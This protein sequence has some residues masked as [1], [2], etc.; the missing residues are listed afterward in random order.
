MGYNSL[1]K[2]KHIFYIISVLVY[3]ICF[4]IFETYLSGGFSCLMKEYGKNLDLMP[5]LQ[6]YNDPQA[7]LLSRV[8]VLYGVRAYP[9]KFILR[10]DGCIHKIV[11]GESPVFYEELERLF[12]KP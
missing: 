1:P 4:T 10:P 3:P 7:E 5:W 6:L 12:D 2:G 11:E 8:N 9:T